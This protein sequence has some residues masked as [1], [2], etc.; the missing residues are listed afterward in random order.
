MTP[1]AFVLLSPMPRAS[2]EFGSS[3]PNLKPIEGPRRVSLRSLILVARRKS[4]VSFVEFWPGAISSGKA[5]APRV[6][7]L[8]KFCATPSTEN[9]TLGERPT[10][11]PMTPTRVRSP[12]RPE[13]GNF[14]SCM[15]SMPTC[16]RRDPG[17]RTSTSSVMSGRCCARA[18]AHKTSANASAQRSRAVFEK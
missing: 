10:W 6:L 8:R 4:P 16:T 14:A 15:K 5:E 1:N 9:S 2:F 11:T 18:A 13:A 3:T 17:S 12:D 7:M